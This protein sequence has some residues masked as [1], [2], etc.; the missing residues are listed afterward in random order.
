[1]DTASKRR[2]GALSLRTLGLGFTV[3][4]D[5]GGSGALGLCS[6]PLRPLGI[7]TLAV[8]LGAEGTGL[9]RLTRENCDALVSIPMRGVVESL[10]VSVATGVLLYEAVRQRQ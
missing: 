3:G 6:F 9:R 1:M 8:V 5:V 10:N 2:L 7:R 4:L